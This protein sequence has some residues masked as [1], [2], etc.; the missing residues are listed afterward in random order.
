MFVRSDGQLN[1]ADVRIRGV[2]ENRPIDQQIDSWKRDEIGK[3]IAPVRRV[4]QAD[5]PQIDL[6][7]GAVVNASFSIGS[8]VK[9]LTMSRR[10]LDFLAPANEVMS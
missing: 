10:S 6:Q 9:L 8:I 5:G 4:F 2:D 3:P 7:T 1:L